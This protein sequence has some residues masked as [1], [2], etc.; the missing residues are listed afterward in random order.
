MNRLSRHDLTELVPLLRQNGLFPSPPSSSIGHVLAPL[1]TGTADVVFS[2][3]QPT[4]DI[5]LGEMLLEHWSP[6]ECQ[7]LE[8]ISL[9]ECIVS[10]FTNSN[11]PFQISLVYDSTVISSTRIGV[12][13]GAS[14]ANYSMTFG[15]YVLPIYLSGSF[16]YAL[17]VVPFQSSSSQFVGR[18]VPGPFI[19]APPTGIVLR[20]GYAT[21]P[22]TNQF[23]VPAITASRYALV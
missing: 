4:V 5:A 11:Y 17:Y 16:L 12:D 21:A 18:A 14:T 13:S 19:E 6:E 2:S 8:F 9:P 20:F 15:L 22:A 1:T 10:S 3:S 7:L 23:H